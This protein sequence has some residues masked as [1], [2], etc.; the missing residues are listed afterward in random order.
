MLDPRLNASLQLK[1]EVTRVCLDQG[2][3]AQAA[4]VAMDIMRNAPNEKAVEDVKGMLI[5][6]GKAELGESLANRMRSDVRST[7]TEGAELARKGDHAG[8]V[9]H[10]MDAAQK[11]PGNALVLYNASLALLK[12]IE[13][14]MWTTATQ[15]R[16]AI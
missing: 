2:L 13:H 15:N 3:E 16:P 9:Q 5:Q 10:F 12:Y 4:T 11:M 8:S 14:W 7:M 1:K 6:M